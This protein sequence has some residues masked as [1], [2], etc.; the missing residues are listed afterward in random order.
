MGRFAVSIGTMGDGLDA[1]MNGHFGRAERFL[2]VDTG[3]ERGTR[4]V[5]NPAR[6]VGHGAGLQAANLV[7]DLAVDAVISGTYGRKAC[8]SLCASGIRAWL[9][10]PALTAGEAL[11]LLRVGRLERCEARVHR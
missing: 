8:E 10:P 3:A 5:I 9:A 1:P 11:A 4:V 6:A 2:V 7:R